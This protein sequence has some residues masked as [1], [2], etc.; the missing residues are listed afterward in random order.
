MNGLENNSSGN[1]SPRF[2]LL[3]I[4]RVLNR[5]LRASLL[6]HLVSVDFFDISNYVLIIFLNLWVSII[7]GTLLLATFVAD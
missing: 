2:R 6:L 1:A 4:I 7:F 5:H 3:C